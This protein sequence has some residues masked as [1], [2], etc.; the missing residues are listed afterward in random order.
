MFRLPVIRVSHDTGFPRI[1]GDVPLMDRSASSDAL[2]SPHTRGCSGR[3]LVSGAVPC[4]FPAYAGM[5]RLRWRRKRL[6]RCF[7]RIRGDVPSMAFHS[8]ITVEFSPHTRGCS[9]CTLICFD[10]YEVFPAYAGMF[11][12]GIL[13]NASSHGFPRI[14][15]D[16]PGILSGVIIPP[17]FSPHTRGCSGLV[18]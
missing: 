11:P 1:R 12:G 14:R 4:V 15:G 3:G 18:G 10:G 2:F 6:V 16:V 7:P 8:Q 5:F 13:E 17:P 9:G